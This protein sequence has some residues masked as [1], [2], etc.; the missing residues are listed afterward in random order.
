MEGWRNECTEEREDV[1][2]ATLVGRSWASPHGHMSRPLP[3][4]VTRAYL[5]PTVGQSATRPHIRL[6]PPS[7]F[8]RLHSVGRRPWHLPCRPHCSYAC[9][10]STR[11][12]CRPSARLLTPLL[13]PCRQATSLPVVA[14]LLPPLELPIGGQP[15]SYV[16]P[17]LSG[18]QHW[19]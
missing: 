18:S 1:L 15:S 13:R 14:P 6:C 10:F 16:L 3:S 19:I 9:D 2:V 12:P 4:S 7:S 5:A 17:N 11:H 8:Y